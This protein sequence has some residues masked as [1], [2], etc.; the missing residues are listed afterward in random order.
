MKLEGRLNTMNFSFE[1]SPCA[2]KDTLDSSDT[3]FRFADYLVDQIMQCDHRLIRAFQGKEDQTSKLCIGSTVGQMCEERIIAY[4]DNISHDEVIAL[5]TLWIEMVQR[6]KNK[7]YEQFLPH[8]RQLPAD[9]VCVI[10]EYLCNFK[11]MTI[12]DVVEHRRDNGLV[13][14]KF[15]LNTPNLA[16]NIR[17]ENDGKEVHIPKKINKLFSFW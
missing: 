8:L 17:G 16:R 2:K 4:E 12:R 3:G 6:S 5:E 7:H 14:Y 13:Q 1:V 15:T 9:C 10:Q 11:V